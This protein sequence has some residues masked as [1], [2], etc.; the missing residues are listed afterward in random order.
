MSKRAKEN[1]LY[2]D[3]KNIFG[4]EYDK[5]WGLMKLSL[6]ML[7]NG[8]VQPCRY[9]IPQ[10][11][12]EKYYPYR[13]EQ[14]EVETTGRPAKDL[15]ENCL[16]TDGCRVVILY[17]TWWVPHGGR[18]VEVFGEFTRSGRLI[19]PRKQ[20]YTGQE[21]RAAFPYR[22]SRLVVEIR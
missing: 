20:L 21:F 19:Q 14:F 8:T 3:G 17:S 6:Q 1:R 12:L 9:W 16:Y 10:D 15:H 5:E 18:R 7:R 13:V 11:E 2:T 4:V 22:V